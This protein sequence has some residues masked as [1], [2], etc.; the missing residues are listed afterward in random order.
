MKTNLP[1]VAITDKKIVYRAE[2][3]RSVTGELLGGLAWPADPAGQVGFVFNEA[4]EDEYA[5]L[6][7][8]LSDGYFARF[9]YAAAKQD[10]RIPAAEE[11]P[12]LAPHA[13]RA[14]EEL[15]ALFLSTNKVFSEQWKKQLK[16]RYAALLESQAREDLP[17][18]R[19]MAFAKNGRAV[20]LFTM[21]R[22]TGYEGLPVDWLHWAWI[23]DTL[24]PGERAFI[25]RRAA[26][27][28][29][30]NVAREIQCNI[31]AFNL[32]SQKF[33]RKLGFLPKCLYIVKE[34]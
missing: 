28:V 4:V 20:S 23:A 30:A 14:P 15:K 12:G 1:V 11:A 29:C 17:K 5:L 7:K 33:F 3:L 22:E 34:R 25:H 18:A 2:T 9:I 26:E 8:N 24:E 6:Q 19:V 27:W 10:I 13:F 21:T 32:R 16:D 31:F